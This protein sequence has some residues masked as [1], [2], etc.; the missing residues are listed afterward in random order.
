MEAIATYPPLSIIWA[1]QM[2]AAF[3]LAPSVSRSNKNGKPKLPN[4]LLKAET[5]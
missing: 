4:H 3:E 5:E 1:L 2:A